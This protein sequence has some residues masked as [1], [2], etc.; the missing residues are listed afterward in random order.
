MHN[1]AWPNI[2]LRDGGMLMTD[3]ERDMVFELVT[4]LCGALV[5]NYE[6]EDLR[7]SPIID[8][9]AQVAA[10]M[11]ASEQ[12]I[13]PIIQEVLRKAADAGRAIGTGLID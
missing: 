11:K 12:Q 9:I 5:V 8:R 10:M 1:F 2:P 13:P 7:D 3:D 6:R 4:V